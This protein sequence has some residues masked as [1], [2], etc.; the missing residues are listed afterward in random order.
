MLVAG[1]AS[2][3]RRQLSDEVA[4]HLRQSILEGK[5]APGESVKAEAVGEALEVSATPVR[6]ALQALRVEGFLELVPRKGFTV[7]PLDA[8]DIR[9]IFEAYALIAGELTARAA[10]RCT[11]EEVAE[12]RGIHEKL[13]AAAEQG[14]RELFEQ[15]N[16]HFH[17]MLY[18]L[19]GSN[20]LQW[21]L[22]SF[23]KYVPRAF[24]VEIE[25]W[26]EASERDHAAIMNAVASGDAETAR[27]HM[28]RHIRASGEKLAETFERRLGL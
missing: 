12:L 28:A 19:S 5:L 20:R 9:D 21:A 25:G 3:S 15:H 17:D 16:D 6:E 27:E 14:D 7:A 22:G 10:Q 8:T 4:S 1:L 24:Y 11:P 2:L 26:P 13:A 18:E 23:V